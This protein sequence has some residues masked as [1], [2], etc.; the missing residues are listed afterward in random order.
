MSP[1]TWPRRVAIFLLQSAM[2]IAP[3]E[4]LDWGHAMLA[5]LHQVE[6]NWAAL[7]WSLGSFGVLVK[8]TL[9]ALIFPSRNRLTVPSVGLFSKEGPVRKTAL[10][11]AGACVIAS[12]LFFLAPVFRQAFRVSLLQWRT[13]VK[14][15]Y[16]SL[17]PE[18]QS[19][20]TKGE[21]DHDAEALAFVAFRGLQ[22]PESARLADEAVRLDSRLAWVYAIVAVREPTVPEIDRWVPALEQF[23]PPNALPYLIAAEKIDIDQILRGSI[24]RRTKD[25]APAWQSA[26]AAAFKSA[27]LDTYSSRRKELDRRVLVRYHVGDPELIVGD[28][29][30]YG[31][32]SYSVS[33]AYRYAEMVLAS[34]QVLEAQGDTRAASERY[35]AIVRFGGLLDPEDSAWFSKRTQQAYTRLAALA[36]NSSRPEEATFYGFLADRERNAEAEGYLSRRRRLSVNPVARWDADLARR[37]GEVML[38][39]GA[40]LLA[41]LFAVVLRSRS[42]RLSSLRPGRLAIG[43]GISSSAA[44]FVSGVVLRLSYQP[45]AE[46]VRRFVRDGDE[47]GLSSLRDFLGRAYAPMGSGWL[48]PRQQ[49]PLYF[50]FAVIFLCALTLLAATVRYFQTRPRT[51][52]TI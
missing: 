33:D 40:L 48:G 47:T 22:S 1:P 30:F 26:M 34:A 12:L 11:I 42:L 35:L 51:S 37:S 14:T 41:T 28:A 7:L 5:E 8:H 36:A 18:L 25:W 15:D 52:A 24:P 9:L 45:Y 39:C 43:V 46:I 3:R 49:Y 32:P 31:L 6:G 10:A 44:L 16:R 19:I 23:D 20:L 21:R 27:R 17:S 50:W 2:S 38:F 29:W 4:T 13:I